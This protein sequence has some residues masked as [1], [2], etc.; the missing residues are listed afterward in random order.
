MLMR[1]ALLA[2]ALLSSLAAVPAAAQ[3]Y[4]DRPISF[5]V[6]WAAGGGADFASRLLAQALER[7]LGIPVNVV[8]RTGGNGVTGHYAIAS[9]APDGYTI[10]M[11]T[12]EIAYLKTTGLSDITPETY[13]IISTVLTFPAG[14]TVR[15]DSPY[16]TAGDFLSALKS[17]PKNAF[18]ASGAG[19]G[20]SWHIA[21]AGLGKA[22]GV[23]ADHV[24]WVPSQGGA[25]ALQEVMAG[26]ITTFSG[27]PGEAKSLADGGRVRI[28]ALMADERSPAFPDVPTLKESGVNWTFTNWFALV[29]PKGL[30]AEVRARLVAAGGKAHATAEVQDPLKQRGFNPAWSGP[31]KAREFALGFATSTRDVLTDLG[32]AKQ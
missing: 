10:G 31:E 3:K 22:A 32:L 6:P 17:N 7:E 8:N 12:S 11:A 5:I 29:A 26:G 24:R 20:G 30:P 19:T 14:I 25:P 21:I 9:A 13:D 28:L 15:S 2:A 4:P 16:K 23:G 27:S 1:R 18:T